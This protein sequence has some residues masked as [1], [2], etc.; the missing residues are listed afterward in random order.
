MKKS[1]TKSKIIMM[2]RQGMKAKD[3][4]DKVKSSI[5]YVYVVRSEMKKDVIGKHIKT[6]LSTTDKPV[7]KDKPLSAYERL[8]KDSLAMSSNERPRIRMQVSPS[9]NI[10]KPYGTDMVNHPPHYTAGG[11]ETIDFIEAKKLGYNLG[12]VVKYITRSDLKGDRLENLKKAQWY[13][14]REVNNMTKD[15]K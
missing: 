15:S 6:I 5:S 3:I 14:N 7:T 2:T 9:T 13:L 8:M 10:V 1:D 4:A 11:I 12:N